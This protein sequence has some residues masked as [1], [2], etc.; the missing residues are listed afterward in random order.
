MSP[1]DLRALSI[2]AIILLGFLT[3]VFWFLAIWTDPGWRWA[4]T[5]VVTQLVGFTLAGVLKWEKDER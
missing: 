5:S 3:P 1:R 2:L 4:A